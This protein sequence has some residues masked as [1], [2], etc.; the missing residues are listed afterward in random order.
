ML[1]QR[2]EEGTQRLLT[3]HRQAEQENYRGDRGG[4]F[5]EVGGKLEKCGILEGRGERVGM[6]IILYHLWARSYSY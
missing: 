3:S 4:T 1:E 2:A 5:R 6:F